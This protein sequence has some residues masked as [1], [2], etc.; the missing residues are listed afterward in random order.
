MSHDEQGDGAREKVPVWLDDA[1]CDALAAARMGKYDGVT[2]EVHL[3]HLI[4]RVRDCCQSS[5]GGDQGEE[6]GS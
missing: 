6:V 5:P 4:R 2:V 1:L 3:E